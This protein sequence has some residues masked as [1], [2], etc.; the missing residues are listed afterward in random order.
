[1]RFQGFTLPTD[2]NSVTIQRAYS[3]MRTLA[4]Y[5]ASGNLEYFGKAMIGSLSASAVWQIRK[6]AYE[7]VGSDDRVS[8]IIWAGDGDFTQVW[9]GRTGLSYA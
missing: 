1:M 5:N 2:D 7:V 3:D 8:S 9:D 6:L 4:D